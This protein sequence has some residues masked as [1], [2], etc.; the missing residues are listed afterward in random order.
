[1]AAQWRDESSYSRDER[2]RV[3]WCWSLA[4]G[5]ILIH[6]V[7]RHRD[8]PGEWVITADPFYIYPR[9][10]AGVDVADVEGAKRAAVEM[11]RSKLRAAIADLPEEAAP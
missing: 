9:V 10:M 2:A 3:P 1:M 11:V 6:I 4:A 7:N 8:Y 5:D